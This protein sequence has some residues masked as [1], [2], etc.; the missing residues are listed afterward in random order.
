MSAP[1]FAVILGPPGTGKTAVIVETLVQLAAAQSRASR[2]ARNR[3]T[4][5]GRR[6]EETYAPTPTVIGVV[7]SVNTVGVVVVAPWKK[8]EH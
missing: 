1:D 6:V 4:H 5:S 3:D 2:C 7:E 8:R